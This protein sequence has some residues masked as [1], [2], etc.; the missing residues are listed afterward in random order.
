M[1]NIPP[2]GPQTQSAPEGCQNTMK[3]KIMMMMMMMKTIMIIMC[4]LYS[5]GRQTRLASGEANKL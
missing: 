2:K 4:F 1:A 5:K 3:M